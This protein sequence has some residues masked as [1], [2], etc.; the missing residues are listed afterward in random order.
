MTAAARTAPEA[1]P[2]VRVESLRKTYD[3]GRVVAVDEVSFDVPA[4]GSLG[5]VGESG[6]GKTTTARLIVGLEEPDAGRVLFDGAEAGT[7]GSRAARRHRARTVQLVFQD[8]Y[9]SLDP[10]QTVGDALDEVLR[11]HRD[12]DGP[13]RARRRAEL[14]GQVGLGTREAAA[15]PRE[16]SG[17]QRQRVAIARALAADPRVLVLDEAVAAL[18]VSI[19]AQIL[20]LLS[21]IRRDT[22]VAL[23]FVSHD[24][25]VVRWVAEDVVVMFRGA[26]IESG[27]TA[28]VLDHPEHPYTRLLLSSVPRLGWDPAEVSRARRDFLATR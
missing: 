23:I 9:Q 5:I 24:L 8:P 3:R 13:G 26:V 28:D 16:L 21:E 14:L 6:S 10:R 27:T 2:V 25:E 12:L 20:N 4:G 15:L 17:G 1:P 7:G 22:G 18:D 19:Q 11:L